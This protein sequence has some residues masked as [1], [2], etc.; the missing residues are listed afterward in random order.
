MFFFK[1]KTPTPPPEEP[2]LPTPEVV[3]RKSFLDPTFMEYLIEL[4]NNNKIEWIDDFRFYPIL[5]TPNSFQSFRCSAHP[6]HLRVDKYNNDLYIDV[7][8]GER[9]TTFNK[10]EWAYGN[11]PT[12]PNLATV[13]QIKEL[14]TTVEAYLVRKEE[15]D[16]LKQEKQNRARQLEL[17]QTV[18]RMI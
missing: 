10:E 11:V 17:E 12:P 7:F 13:D 18:L 15:I 9:Y 4:T 1:K 14:I 2:P 3:I 16:R 8:T 5:T 6:Y